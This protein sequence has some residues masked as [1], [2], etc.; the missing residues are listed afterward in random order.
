[1]IGVQLFII[2]QSME[3]RVLF[4]K[5]VTLFSP[6]Y[7]GDNLDV[8]VNVA[9]CSLCPARRAAYHVRH[10][11]CPWAPNFALWPIDHNIQR[12]ATG[13]AMAAVEMAG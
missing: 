4:K 9:A 2:I 7:S 13:D 8:N 10:W 12:P 1:M 11:N 6:L 3:F 5:I